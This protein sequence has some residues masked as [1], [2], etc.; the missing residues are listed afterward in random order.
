MEGQLLQMIIIIGI[1][2]M[3]TEIT[4]VISTTEERETGIDREIGK[5]TEKES[6]EIRKERARERAAGV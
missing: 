3:K 5:E 2:T 1:T 4:I 6:I